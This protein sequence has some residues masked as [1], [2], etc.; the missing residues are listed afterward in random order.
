M[1]DARKKTKQN[2]T[3]LLDPDLFDFKTI[4]FEL[5]KKD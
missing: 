2:K 3:E 5:C 4:G 1:T